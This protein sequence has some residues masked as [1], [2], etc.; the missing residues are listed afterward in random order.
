MSLLRGLLT[1]IEPTFAK[2]ACAKCGVVLW[3]Y[4]LRDG[5]C[6]GCRNPELVVVAVT[7]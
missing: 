7:E 5:I 2:V 6:G 1:E 4:W 3:S